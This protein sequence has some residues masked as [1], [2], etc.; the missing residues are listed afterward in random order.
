MSGVR[1]PDL[2]I[3]NAL[4]AGENL[5]LADLDK[6]V[7][8]IFRCR[9]VQEQENIKEFLRYGVQEDDPELAAQ[10]RI[11][12]FLGWPNSPQELPCWAVTMSEGAETTQGMGMTLEDQ[13]PGGLQ[14]NIE[15]GWIASGSIFQGT[16]SIACYAVNPNLAA[17]LQAM[18]MFILLLQRSAIENE[19]IHSQWLNFNDLRPDPQA[20]PEFVFVREIRLRCSWENY[21]VEVPPAISGI[22]LVPTI[23][24]PDGVTI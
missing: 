1:I 11:K 4:I 5:I 24:T 15:N 21:W 8:E 2:T 3:L 6:W 17:Y 23:I 12:K 9:S 18:A 10:Y 20:N 22:D 16:I 13:T 19:G 14:E 7:P